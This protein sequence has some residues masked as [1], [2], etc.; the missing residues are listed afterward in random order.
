MLMSLCFIDSIYQRIQH[1]L[2]GASP[3]QRWAVVLCRIQDAFF[4]FQSALR[5]LG[6]TLAGAVLDRV[7]HG[8]LSASGESCL[9]Y[10]LSWRIQTNGRHF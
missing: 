10:I 6:F 5:C 2:I 9:R 7:D 8:V 1:L 3:F 4:R